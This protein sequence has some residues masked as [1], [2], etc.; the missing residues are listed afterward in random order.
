MESV[1]ND[2]QFSGSIHYYSSSNSPKSLRPMLRTHIEVKVT[3][4]WATVKVTAAGQGERVVKAVPLPAIG[5]PT[6][7]NLPSIAL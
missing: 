1:K 3:Y 2:M 5:K 4:F 6:D 7:Y